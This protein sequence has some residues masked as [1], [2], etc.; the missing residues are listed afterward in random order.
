MGFDGFGLCE[1]FFPLGGLTSLEEQNTEPLLL[2]M[3]YIG[4]DLSPPNRL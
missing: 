1:T 2:F 4:N 3:L